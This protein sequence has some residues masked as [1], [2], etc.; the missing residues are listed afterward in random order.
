MSL[1]Q[2]RTCQA[3]ADNAIGNAVA[4]GANSIGGYMAYRGLYGDNASTGGTADH[5]P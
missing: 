4:T 1:F 5:Y 3:A 2:E